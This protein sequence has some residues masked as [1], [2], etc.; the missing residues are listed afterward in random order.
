MAD[1]ERRCVLSDL[2]VSQCAHCRNPAPRRPEYGPWFTAQYPGECAGP[3]GGDIEPGDTIRADGAGDW[4]C[5]QC[6]S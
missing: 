3:C 6:G 1:G 5:E 4:L 2:P